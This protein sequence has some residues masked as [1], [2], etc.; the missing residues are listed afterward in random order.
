MCEHCQ[1]RTCSTT[2]IGLAKTPSPPIGSKK[3]SGRASPSPSGGGC[4]LGFKSS[5]AV[6]PSYYL[7]FINS[8]IQ[9]DSK[10]LLGGNYALVFQEPRALDPLCPPTIYPSTI[11]ANKGF[12]EYCLGSPRWFFKSSRALDLL[13]TP[14]IYTSTILAT[15]RIQK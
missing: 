14:T 15:Q 4:A 1:V 9:T 10:I 2:S 12:R 13:C 3:Q 8:C 11:L 5:R 6:M 7:T